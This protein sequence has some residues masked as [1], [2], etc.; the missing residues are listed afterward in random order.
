MKRHIRWLSLLL[1]IVM[2][3]TLFPEITLPTRAEDD[4]TDLTI[5]LQYKNEFTGMA[6]ADVLNRLGKK[7]WTATVTTEQAYKDAAK[8]PNLWRH[9]TKLTVSDPDEGS[10]RKYLTS[11]DP[12]DTYISV[13]NDYTL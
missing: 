9:V 5:D 4:Y 3:V 7:D 13:M 8:N 1:A 11:T 10:L 2:L 12:N 6:P